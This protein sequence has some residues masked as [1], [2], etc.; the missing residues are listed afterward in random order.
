MCHEVG[1]SSG[2][3]FGLNVMIYCCQG[4]GCNGAGVVM[5]TIGIVLGALLSGLLSF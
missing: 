1:E 2:S 4:D 3:Y 5:P